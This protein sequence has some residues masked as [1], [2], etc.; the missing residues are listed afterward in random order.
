MPSVPKPEQCSFEEEL[1]T[2]ASEDTQIHPRL[3]RIL[4]TFA[5]VSLCIRDL[6]DHLMIMIL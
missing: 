1:I 3:R 5:E 6:L 4:K 2:Q